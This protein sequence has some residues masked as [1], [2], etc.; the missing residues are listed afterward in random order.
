MKSVIIT[1]ATGMIGVNIARLALSQGYEVLC[2]IRTGSEKE[3][4]LPIDNKLKIIY[5][6]ISNYSKI[7]IDGVYDAF[8]HLAPRD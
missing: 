8:F 2:I 4:R 7:E 5:S 6:D 1:G 3:K